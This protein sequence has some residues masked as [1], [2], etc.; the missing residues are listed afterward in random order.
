MKNITE[1]IIQK[2]GLI[3]F[4]ELEKGDLEIFTNFDTCKVI[5]KEIKKNWSEEKIFKILFDALNGDFIYCS[6][7][8]EL[9][10]F[11]KYFKTTNKQSN[12]AEQHFFVQPTKP[13]MVDPKKRYFIAN[14]AVP[15]LQIENLKDVDN[16]TS[17]EVEFINKVKDGFAN[18]DIDKSFLNFLEDYKKIVAAEYQRKTSQNKKAMDEIEWFIGNGFFIPE[19][20]L[21]YEDKN[22]ILDIIVYCNIAALNWLLIPSNLSKY[23]N[24]HQNDLLGL[25]KYLYLM[26]TILAETKITKLRSGNV[27][28]YCFRKKGYYFLDELSSEEIDHYCEGEDYEVWIVKSKDN[29]IEPETAEKAYDAYGNSYAYD[30][31]EL[32]DTLQKFISLNEVQFLL[33]K[34]I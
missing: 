32:K 11:I 31:K 19:Q 13:Y 34:R 15:N 1:S 20:I 18:P 23:E 28:E 27:E 5:I 7:Q 14:L 9:Q 10:A 29:E 21:K 2:L 33:Y 25:T 4:E 16:L 24:I 17:R 30:L 3:T 12:K 8:Q 22:K 26:Q 6:S